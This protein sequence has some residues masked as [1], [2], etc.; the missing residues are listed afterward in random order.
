MLNKIN[1][2]KFHPIEGDIARYRQMQDL[3]IS[4]TDCV[5]GPGMFDLAVNNAGEYC[6]VQMN[7]VEDCLLKGPLPPEYWALPMYKVP[8]LPPSRLEV[9]A[10]FVVSLCDLSKCYDR[11]TAA[12]ITDADF[13]QIYSIGVNGGPKGSTYNCLCSIP[14]K[15]TC[16]HAEANAIAKCT[17]TD[18]QKT[19]ICSLSPCV[20]CA[21]LIVNSGFSAVYF[22]E[23]YKDSTG[24]EILTEAG[25]YV[26][27][28]QI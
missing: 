13:T 22:I 12:I 14:G 28:L 16:I 2:M 9:M 27:K 10:K 4:I 18:M 8:A 23:E 25:I 11:H 24:L 5:N 6:R 17:S 3:G 26:N 1:D 19:M 7:T 15:Y 20:T 21:S